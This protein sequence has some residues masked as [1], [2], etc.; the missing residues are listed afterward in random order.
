MLKRI[1][2]LFLFNGL[3][4]FGYRLILEYTPFVGNYRI[5][6]MLEVLFFIISV[7]LYLAFVYF[8]MKSLSAKKRMKFIIIVSVVL[9]ASA[10]IVYLGTF[11]GITIPFFIYIPLSYLLLFSNV[12]GFQLAILFNLDSPIFNIGIIV[13]SAIALLYLTNWIFFFKDGI[14]NKV[15]K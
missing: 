4:V 10:S 14:P 9:L 3:L 6:E 5:V 12:V 2:G 1:V 8:L 13:L 7:V 11:S 15:K